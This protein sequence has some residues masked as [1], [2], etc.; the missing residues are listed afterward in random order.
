MKSSSELLQRELRLL[1]LLVT[2]IVEVNNILVS[3]F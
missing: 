2:R 3:D 1:P